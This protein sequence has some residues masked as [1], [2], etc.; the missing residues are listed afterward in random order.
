MIHRLT[1]RVDDG[2]YAKLQKLAKQEHCSL[3]QAMIY[4]IIH[5]NNNSKEE[6][7]KHEDGTK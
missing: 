2:V 7:D 5:A 3:N 4:S 1:C 6:G